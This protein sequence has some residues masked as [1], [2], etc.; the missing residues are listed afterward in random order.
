MD[1]RGFVCL[2]SEIHFLCK[3]T[4]PLQEDRV[5]RGVLWSWAE[6]ELNGKRVW[7]SSAVEER[8]GQSWEWSWQVSCRT[9][10]V[11]KLEVRWPTAHSIGCR[12]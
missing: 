6:G 3:R 8:I 4:T 2:I 7:G 11:G 5:D 10:G 1:A 12:S 9:G